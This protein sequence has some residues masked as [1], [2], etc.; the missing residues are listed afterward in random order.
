MTFGGDELGLR[1]ARRRLRAVVADDDE[2][3]RQLLAAVLEL[4]GWEVRCASDGDE[5]VSMSAGY[6]PDAVFLDV[7]M[8][9]SDGISALRRLRESESGR[10]CAIVMV[11]GSDDP[12]AQLAAADAGCD[13]YLLKPLA[14]DDVSKR[15]LRLVTGASRRVE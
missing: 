3:M 14:I 8:P 15:V 10:D 11:S 1:R 4:D 5:A 13:D 7:K 12:R 9:G 6:E 2:G